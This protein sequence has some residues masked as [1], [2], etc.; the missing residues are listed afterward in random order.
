M[1]K[2]GG[3]KLPRKRFLTGEF[4]L[5]VHRTD[6]GPVDVKLLDTSVTPPRSK[7]ITITEEAYQ[8]RL[9]PVFAS[10]EERVLGGK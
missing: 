3:K 6:S 5:R 8:A 9:D 10:D 4:V 2:L 7:W 1:L